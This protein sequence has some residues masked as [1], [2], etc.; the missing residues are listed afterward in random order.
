M[1]HFHLET[2][3]AGE[4]TTV[5]HATGSLDARSAPELMSQCAMVR[6]AGRHLVLNLSAIEFIASSGV[7]VLLALVEEFRNSRTRVLICEASPAIL[8]VVKL[9]NLEAFLNLS[10]GEALAISQLEAVAIEP[11]ERAA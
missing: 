7:G 8:S 11:E 6:A 2:R 1:T 4:R 10:P 9:L 5:I 3:S